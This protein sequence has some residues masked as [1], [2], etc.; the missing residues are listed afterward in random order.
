MIA[1][2]VWSARLNDGRLAL[3][4]GDASAAVTAL[5]EVVEA[6]PESLE[7]GAAARWLRARAHLRAGAAEA[8]LADLRWLAT[9]P[10]PPELRRSAR[11][12]LRAQGKPESELRPV[13]SP[14]EEWQALQKLLEADDDQ[15]P[16]E[17]ERQLCSH[18]SPEFLAAARRLFGGIY[19]DMLREVLEQEPAMLV[20]E[21]VD[22]DQGEAELRFQ[23]SDLRYRVRWVQIGDRWRIS[24]IDA[25][26]VEDA[27][28]VMV[29]M[30]EL[31]AADAAGS[32]PD[33]APTN[34]AEIVTW[35]QQLAHDDPR[36]RARARD[37]LAARLSMVRSILRAYTNDPDPEIRWTIRELLSRP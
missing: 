14:R 33:A 10:V 11:E 19:L 17:T 35:V 32:T 2:L 18:L 13:R 24:S 20:G 28:D 31:G 4:R 22:P 15:D 12:L 29:G 3:E 5:T 16:Q 26:R 36:V 1:A 21:Q 8:A 34:T 9:R 6:Q 27:G 23:Q 25:Q 37:E 30:P 7:L